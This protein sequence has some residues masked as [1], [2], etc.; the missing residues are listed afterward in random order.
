MKKIEYTPEALEDLQKLKLRLL[1]EFG[2]CVS[3]K[4]LRKITKDIRTLE[5]FENAG[6]EL[7]KMYG[8]VSDYRSLYTAKNYAV[9]RVEGEKVK[10]IRVLDERMDFMRILF[11]IKIVEEDDDWEEDRE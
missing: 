2:E 11:G 9:Y 4:I 7:A 1:E 10:I 8:I 5:I 3:K 6:V